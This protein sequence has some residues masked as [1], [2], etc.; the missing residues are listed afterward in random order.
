M[1]CNICCELLC[2]SPYGRCGA[3]RAVGKR[4]SGSDSPQVV[5]Q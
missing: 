1:S 3:L 4:D 5:A 2:F